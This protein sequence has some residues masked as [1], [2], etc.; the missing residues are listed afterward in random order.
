VKIDV[1]TEFGARVARRLKSEIVVWL[2]TVQPN[3]TPQPSPVWFYWDGSS[4][5]IY[6]QPGKVKV[7]D[8]AT[9]SRV[10]LNFDSD[11]DGG[12]IVVIIGDAREDHTTPP[13]NLV[14]EYLAKYKTHIAGIGMTPESFAR[15]YSVPIRVTPARLRGF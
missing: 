2:T 4:V 5:L 8:I 13:A 15:D 10:A 9:N 6:S 11:S 7:K 1:T 12:D 14:T 3:G